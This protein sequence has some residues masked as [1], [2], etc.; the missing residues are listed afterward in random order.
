MSGGGRNGMTC[1]TNCPGR[2][3]SK[4]KGTSSSLAHKMMVG[5]LTPRQP[6]GRTS[7]WVTERQ[8]RNLV[9]AEGKIASKVAAGA[10]AV[11]ALAGQVDGQGRI[12]LIQG[13]RIRTG[14]AEGT[15]GSTFRPFFRRNR[16][17]KRLADCPNLHLPRIA[18]RFSGGFLGAQW[19]CCSCFAPITHS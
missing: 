7:F 3:W 11:L 18:S 17:K 16:C 4:E 10:P 5:S 1:N 6:V 12:S 15:R 19:L 9:D 8:Q 14:G 2:Q 13:A